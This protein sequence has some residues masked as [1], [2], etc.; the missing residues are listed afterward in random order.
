MKT[1]KKKKKNKK[2]K[3]NVLT[4]LWKQLTGDKFFDRIIDS[5]HWNAA[6]LW[7]KLSHRVDS[8]YPKAEEVAKAVMSI[9]QSIET[10]QLSEDMYYAVNHAVHVYPGVY[11]A[12]LGLITSYELMTKYSTT[13]SLIADKCDIPTSKNGEEQLEWVADNLSEWSKELH[14]P[15]YYICADHKRQRL[16]LCIRGSSSIRDIVTDLN[17]ES[18]MQSFGTTNCVVGLCHEGILQSA[19]YVRDLVE[20]K[21][22][23][24]LQL[25]ETQKKHVSIR[26]IFITGH[27]LG[28]GVAS[29]LALLWKDDKVIA[30]LM[31]VFAF[32]SP[33]VV[34]FNIA[35]K[36]LSLQN[37]VFTINLGS[38]VVTRLSLESLRQGYKRMDLIKSYPKSVLTLALVNNIFQLLFPPPLPF[39]FPFAYTYK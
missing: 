12:T 31:K 15:K 17:A 28:A 24:Y 34:S 27:S 10:W 20:G 5:K 11:L 3:Y 16:V 39:F 8:T 19:L 1:P 9:E 21:I 22:K 29:M 2:K 13:Q 36:D 35:R 4:G 33:C 38:D 25:C 7:S 32:A 23:K 37:K 18:K 26:E 14:Q 6:Q 30:P